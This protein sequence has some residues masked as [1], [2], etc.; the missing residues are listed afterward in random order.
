MFILYSILRKSR[1]ESKILLP[2]LTREQTF[3][4]K[5]YARREGATI[6]M[7]ETQSPL[8]R[9]IFILAAVVIVILG[10][11]YA[12]EFLA[13]I[14]LAVLLAILFAPALRWLEKRGLPTSLAL[15]V[16][17]LF[18]AAFFVL[19]ILILILSLNQLETRL[20]IYQQLLTMRLTSLQT[21]LTRLGL[22]GGLNLSILEGTSLARTAINVVTGLLSN[23]VGLVF[24]LF[25]LFLMLAESGNITRNL[26]ASSA[27]GSA[28]S[29]Q[30][31]AYSKQIQQQYRIQALSNLLSAVAIT[32]ELL[33]FRVDLAFLWGFLA[34]VLGFIPNVGLI[35]A[36]LP[37]VVIA[38]I[39]YGPGT[40]LAI[41]I[42]GILLNAIMDNLVTPRFMGAGL[43]LPLLP[44]FFSFLLWSWVFG[45]L[46]ALLAV[47][48]TL[49][50]RTFF[51]SRKEGRFLMIFLTKQKS[52]EV[53]DRSPDTAQSE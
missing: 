32:V 31:T 23:V 50:L 29:V 12:G 45:F 35:I 14:F 40:A 16:L 52:A 53:A 19:L 9:Q 42:V 33:L 5:E 51:Q 24:F 47:P 44:I 48:A 22:A 20:P 8:A 21:L 11:K 26:R 28:F 3:F 38:L 15:F 13:P 36:T 46:G 6:A 27:E 10:L 30:F 17:I 4:W 18:L 41:V 39:L 1:Q 2:F 34:F 25:L 37:A 7:Y 43:N 49:L